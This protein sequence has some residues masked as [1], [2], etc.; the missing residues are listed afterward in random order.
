MRKFEITRLILNVIVYFN[1]LLQT[2][3]K[4]IIEFE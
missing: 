3:E 1:T 4:Q 2:H